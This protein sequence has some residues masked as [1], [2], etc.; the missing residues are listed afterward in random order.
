MLE[1]KR[2]ILLVYVF[3]EAQPRPRT[4]EQARKCCLTHRERIAPQVVA[5][6]LDQVEGVEEHGRIVLPIPNAVERRDPV[7]AACNR[8]A[9]DDAGVGAK[10]S[11]RLNNERE[12]LGK[13]VAWTAV[14]LHPFVVLAGDNPEAVVLD[15]VQ[16][17]LAGRWLRGR[18]GEAGRNEAC[19][20][21]MRTEG[22]G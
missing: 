11:E 5:I 16:P 1:H 8:L 7:I 18:R 19:R 10:P 2:A 9:I 21:G 13:V 22:H 6:K 3:V 12:T 17:F 15:F 4:R 20:E 14:K